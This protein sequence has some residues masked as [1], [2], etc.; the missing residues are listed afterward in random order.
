VLFYGQAPR[1]N[2][3]GHPG[4]ARALPVAGGGPPL[5]RLDRD[6]LWRRLH[7]LHPALPRSGQIAQHFGVEQ[8]VSFLSAACS[9]CGSLWSS[10]IKALVRGGIT[11]RGTFYPLGELRRGVWGAPHGDAGQKRVASDEQ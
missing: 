1:Q 2:S 7:S 9:S 8:R 3:A 4:A 11:W 10:A 5:R 6:P